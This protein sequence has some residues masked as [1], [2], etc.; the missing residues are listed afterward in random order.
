LDE[1]A[2]AF[3]ENYEQVWTEYSKKKDHMAWYEFTPFEVGCDEQ[4]GKHAYKFYLVKI[5]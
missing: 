3:V 4:A 2:S 1:K 5:S